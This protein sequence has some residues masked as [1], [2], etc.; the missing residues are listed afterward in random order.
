M[1][2]IPQITREQLLKSSVVGV[3]GVNP[4]PAA[5]GQ[6]I[7]A[8]ATEMAGSGFDIAMKL[9]GER[10]EGE[11]A[12][13]MLDHS[14]NIMNAAEQI[15]KQDADHPDDMSRD[16]SVAM[17]KSLEIESQRASNPFVKSFLLRFL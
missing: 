4:L 9:Q 13:L 1:A 11:F 10:N 7:G 2:T 15:K 12:S 6:A 3:P 8:G 5:A 14:Q 17:A 16:L